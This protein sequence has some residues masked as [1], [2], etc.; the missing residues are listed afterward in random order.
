MYKSLVSPAAIFILVISESWAELRFWIKQHQQVFFFPQMDRAS[1]K[2][3]EARQSHAR[4]SRGKALG[5]KEKQGG[6]RVEDGSLHE[7]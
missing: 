7:K 6:F 3:E 4:R 1:L 2:R 5:L